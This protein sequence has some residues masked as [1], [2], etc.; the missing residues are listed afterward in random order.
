[1]AGAGADSGA[2]QVILDGRCFDVVLPVPLEHPW[3]L[4][5][6]ALPRDK[7]PTSPITSLLARHVPARPS[8]PCSPVTSLPAH[9]VP[10]LVHAAPAGAARTAD[11]DARHLTRTREAGSHVARRPPR[12]CGLLRGFRGGLRPLARRGAATACAE[13]GCDRLRGGGLLSAGHAMGW[14]GRAR[15]RVDHSMLGGRHGMV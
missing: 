13:G 10:L 4:P 2:E 5:T 9:H 3:F 15:V 6:V 14:T 12:T 8:R 11:A 1:M 7:V